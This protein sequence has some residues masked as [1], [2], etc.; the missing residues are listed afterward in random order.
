MPG[1]A[2]SR[3]QHL[4]LWV[5]ALMGPWTGPIAAEPVQ[6]EGGMFAVE[7]AGHGLSARVCQIVLD[8]RDQ[9]AQCGLVQTQAVTVQIVEGYAQPDIKCLASLDCAQGVIRVADPKSYAGLLEEGDPYAL[10]PADVLLQALL[11]HE[12]AHALVEQTADG[13]KVAIVDQEYI[14]AAMELEFLDEPWRTTLVEA[15]P[16]PDPP[17]LGLIDFWIY[18]LEPRQFATNAWRHFSLP[19]NGCPLVGRIVSGDY[20]FGRR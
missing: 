4:V 3:R 6:C 11:T 9:L 12:L 17:A 13:R 14:A 19:E 16:P 20:T 7:P 15:S 2:R 5:I 1:R 8:A 10:L 18:G